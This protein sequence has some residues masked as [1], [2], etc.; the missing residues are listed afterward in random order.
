MKIGFAKADSGSIFYLA[1]K[2]KPRQSVAIAESPGL[3]FL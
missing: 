3:L 1:A 2:E